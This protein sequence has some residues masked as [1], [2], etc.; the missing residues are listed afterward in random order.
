[1]QSA[2]V[3]ASRTYI[4][5][6]LEKLEAKGQAWMVDLSKKYP[7]AKKLFKKQLVR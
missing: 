2:I 6:W 3:I 4:G 1:M 7:S 5:P